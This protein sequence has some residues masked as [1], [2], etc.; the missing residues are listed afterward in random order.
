MTTER[1]TILSRILQLTLLLSLLRRY[2]VIIRDG[3]SSGSDIETFTTLLLL[4]SMLLEKSFRLLAET[5]INLS[6]QGN[7]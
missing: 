3:N 2:S 6:L 5:W 1:W 4:N 7:Y